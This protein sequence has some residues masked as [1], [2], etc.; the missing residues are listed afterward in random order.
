MKIEELNGKKIGIFGFG[1]EGESLLLYF[2]KHNIGDVT[3]FDEG[4]LSDKKLD[5]IKNSG[6]KF[7]SGRFNKES[8]AGIEIAFRSPGLR[9]QKIRDLLS[10][11]TELTTL[12][13]LFFA[14]HRGKIVAVTGT[15]GKSTTVGLIAE[16]LGQNEIK[17]FVGGNI[18]NPPLE[19]LDETDDD[20]F[21]ILELSSFQT[22]DLQYSPDVALFL[23][24]T[25]DHLSF[26][27]SQ[28][29][30]F[31]FHPT[32]ENYLSSKAQLISKMGDDGIII[33]YDAE[34]I[35]SFV[36]QSSAKKI[37]F[38]QSNVENGCGQ[39]QNQIVCR[40]GNDTQIYNDVE[41]LCRENKIPQID[42]IA[43]I[44]FAYAMDLRADIQKI[45][46]GFKKL[47]FRIEFIDEID[48]VKYYNDSAATNP[49]STIEA[50]KTI[51]QPYVLIMGGSS[52]GLA[53]NR[54]AKVA[55]SDQNIS[56]IY[57]FGQTSDE[58]E[59]ELIASN[60]K[61]PLFKKNSLSEVMSDIKNCPK[62]FSAVLFSPASASFDQFKSYRD[63]GESFN[64]LVKNAQ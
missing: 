53:F 21:T 61:K 1:T 5:I 55:S 10:E 47:P 4:T 36:S 11:E 62:N 56:T 35:R 15:K 33:A 46:Q 63:R 31:N 59:S 2:T 22:E 26:H 51:A 32:M 64:G 29:E 14:N 30:H 7:V 60:F 39:D 52:K 41:M 20:S 8:S 37:Y 40:G 25:S 27:A 49:V 57:L 42:L 3:I 58:I 54:L 9:R 13:N 43:A 17:Y 48:G 12:T 6:A 38:S 19:F 50:M 24:I 16:V 45:V 44:S 28:G 18:G 34:K 23:P